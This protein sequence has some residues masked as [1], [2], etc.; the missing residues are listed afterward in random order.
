MSERWPEV[1]VYHFQNLV[2][3]IG[4]QS[5]SNGGDQP[6]QHENNVVSAELSI[7]MSAAQ[8]RWHL[9]TVRSIPSGSP[10]VKKRKA[11]VILGIC[12]NLR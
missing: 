3:N 8:S 11:N 5:P 9:S 10:V 7:N 1:L 6:Q 4:S 12:S 2:K